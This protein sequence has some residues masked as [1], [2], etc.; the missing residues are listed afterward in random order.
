MN[1][2]IGQAGVRMM[3]LEEYY[4]PNKWIPFAAAMAFHAALL[5][6]DPTILK[7]SPY[8]FA[9]QIINVRMMDHLPVLEPVKPA[10]TPVEKKIEKKHVKKAKKSGLSL[11]TKAVSRRPATARRAVWRAHPVAAPKPFVSKI[12]M[13]K[14]VPTE[15]DEPIAASPLPGAAPAAKH[16]MVQAFAPAPKLKGKSRGVRASDIPFQLSDRG[17]LGSSADRIVAVPIG[18]ERGEIASLPSAPKIHEAPKGLKAVAGYRFSPGEGS[19]SGELAG[20]DKSG[21]IGYHGVVKAD[22]YVEGAIS[23]VSGKGRGKVVAG[24]GF[25]IGGP[26]GDRK[27]AHRRLPEYPAWAE[28]KGISAMVKVYFTVRPDGTLRSNLRIVTSSGY[29][30]LDDLAKEALLQWR[31][32]PTSANSSEESAWGVITFRFTL[33]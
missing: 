16:R 26:V 24:K 11:S 20:R 17:S 9:A 32:S 1:L 3:T 27:I 2:P 28:E 10:P 29:A 6:W 33:A 4:L 25:E 23:G 14:F 21:H 19:G 12:T 15:T 5:M 30:E 8:N 13:P 18:E 7:A 31:F 22:T